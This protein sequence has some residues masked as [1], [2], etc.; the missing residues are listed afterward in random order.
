MYTVRSRGAA[1]TFCAGACAENVGPAICRPGCREPGEAA[2]IR[3]AAVRSRARLHGRGDAAVATITER[4]PSPAPSAAAGG[5][6]EADHTAAPKTLDELRPLTLPRIHA[7]GGAADAL[8]D[9]CGEPL[10][11][12]RRM[13]RALQHHARALRDPGRGPA[14]RRLP[15]ASEQPAAATTDMTEA[16]EGHLARSARTGSGPSIADP[17]NRHGMALSSS[18]AAPGQNRD[19][20]GKHG[21]APVPLTA[22]PG[23]RNRSG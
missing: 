9:P 10:L 8:R 3:S 20:C 4:T 6:P 17:C 22:H 1:S 7:L 23:A 2:E 14:P 21:I 19:Q 18:S 5:P 12:D 15:A 13:E 11:L 16:E